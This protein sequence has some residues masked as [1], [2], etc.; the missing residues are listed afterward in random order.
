MGYSPGTPKVPKI[1]YFL[2]PYGAIKY[3][4]Y[5]FFRSRRPIKMYFTI[6]IVILTFS[7]GREFLNVF[8]SF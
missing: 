2:G 3:E 1:G 5:I 6:Y 7:N 8:C 4:I